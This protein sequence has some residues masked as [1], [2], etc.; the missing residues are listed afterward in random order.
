MYTIAVQFPET[1]MTICVESWSC[2]MVINV[3][4]L[5]R[6]FNRSQWQQVTLPSMPQREQ[7]NRILGTRM[8]KRSP[9]RKMDKNMLI[10]KRTFDLDSPNMPGYTLDS[11]AAAWPQHD[12]FTL[13]GYLFIYFCTFVF[14]SVKYIHHKVVFMG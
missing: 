6:M 4:E 3:I 14:L 9:K 7:M 2:R 8:Q 12:N 10:C 1:V 5:L 11:T 13:S